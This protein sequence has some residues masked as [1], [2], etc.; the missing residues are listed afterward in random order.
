MSYKDLS[1]I[2]PDDVKSGSDFLDKI[3]EENDPPTVE[4]TDPLP[5]GQKNPL[6]GGQLGVQ[7]VEHQKA[8][9]AKEDKA[10]EDK[11][12]KALLSQLRNWQSSYQYLETAN[13]PRPIPGRLKEKVSRL[14]SHGFDSKLTA[15]QTVVDELK[16]VTGHSYSSPPDQADMIIKANYLIELMLV[17]SGYDVSGFAK[18]AAVTCKDPLVMCLIENDL[19]SGMKINPLYVLGLTYIS[20]LGSAYLKNKA[21]ASP[22]GSPASNVGP[23]SP[24][25]RAEES[26]AVSVAEAAASLPSLSMPPPPPEAAPAI[27]TDDSGDSGDY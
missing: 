19:L 4:E 17:K 10:K 9:M 20:V 8:D 24:A 2:I 11:E 18:E 15:L 22:P 3:I 14:L 1:K 6:P 27:Q 25:G 12:K 26:P 23:A 13:P 5:G 7:I 16:F 21:A